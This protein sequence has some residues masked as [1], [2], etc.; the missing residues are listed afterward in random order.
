MLICNP[1]IKFCPCNIYK[2]FNVSL[3]HQLLNTWDKH[4]NSVGPSTFWG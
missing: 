3:F 4:S 1:L 2:S